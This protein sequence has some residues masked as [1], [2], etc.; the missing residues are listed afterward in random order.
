MDH[1]RP[2]SFQLKEA[3]PLHRFQLLCSVCML[4]ALISRTDYLI[5][6]GFSNSM[7]SRKYIDTRLAAHVS[8]PPSRHARENTIN[9]ARS[10]VTPVSC[11]QEK[12]LP[13]FSAFK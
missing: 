10:G 2:S 9:N 13:L 1:T 11:K 3:K 12:R 5:V 7:I 4:L 8:V 6:F